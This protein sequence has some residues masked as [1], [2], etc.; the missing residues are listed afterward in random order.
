MSAIII[1]LDNY[2]S[3]QSNHIRFDS[4]SGDENVATNVESIPCPSVSLAYSGSVNTS[5]INRT[6]RLSQIQ[7]SLEDTTNIENIQKEPRKEMRK[8]RHRAIDFRKDVYTNKSIVLESTRVEKGPQ[9]KVYFLYN[10]AL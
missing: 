3:K 7:S 10:F 9:V 5:A 6:S 1:F 8:G 4:E 2:H